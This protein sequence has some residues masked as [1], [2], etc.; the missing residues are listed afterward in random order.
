MVSVLTELKILRPTGPINFGGN[1]LGQELKGL[2]ARGLWSEYARGVVS[3]GD[4]G[5]P[6]GVKEWCLTQSTGVTM[7]QLWTN[8][9]EVA[10]A[11]YNELA[12]SCE[13]LLEGLRQPGIGDCVEYIEEAKRRLVAVD[14]AIRT[15]L[16]GASR[17]AACRPVSSTS[18]VV[19]G[20]LPIIFT[21]GWIRVVTAALCDIRQ[22]VA[23]QLAMDAGA[24][25]NTKVSLRSGTL[26]SNGLL[27]SELVKLTVV[28]RAK[29]HSWF[30]MSCARA[31]V[32][33]EHALRE[34]EVPIGE[35]QVLA[36]V[37]I[38]PV[39]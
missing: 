31:C 20:V 24:S 36:P 6:T 28:D 21:S 23:C 29:D 39:T 27:H 8:G 15:A 35:G 4:L 18:G 25:E 11:K 33:L 30:V 9:L 1:R 13:R 17:G 38:D 10:A 14:A 7:F 5:E 26:L 2:R 34:I 19:A 37:L 22:N 3:L 12:E 32:L 16:P